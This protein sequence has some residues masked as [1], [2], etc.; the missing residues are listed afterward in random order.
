VDKIT[1][2]KLSEAL[3]EHGLM[4]GDVPP[5]LQYEGVEYYL[6]AI[7]K[8]E[9][10]SMKWM[11]DERGPRAAAIFSDLTEDTYV[12]KE[13][14]APSGYLIPDNKVRKITREDTVDVGLKEYP[15]LPSIGKEDEKSST[16]DRDSRLMSIFFTDVKG[17]DLPETGEHGKGIYVAA[18][19]ALLIAAMASLPLR[20]WRRERTA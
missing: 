2:G 16:S 1:D 12:V 18:G 6:Q 13:L 8:T 7:E 14:K 15:V 5:T 9:D 11:P 4:S 17:Y 19:A 10:R 20:H 3:S